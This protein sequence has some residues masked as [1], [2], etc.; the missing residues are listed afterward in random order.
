MIFY[1]VLASAVGVL[2]TH[3]PACFAHCHIFLPS[4][5]TLGCS[6]VT[7]VFV[8]ELNTGI[9]ALN[10]AGAGFEDDDDAG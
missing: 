3:S 8:F 9:G 1:F 4:P 7:V 2:W 6:S 5:Y 10:G